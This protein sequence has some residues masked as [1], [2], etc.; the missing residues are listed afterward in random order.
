[1]GGKYGTFAIE[2]DV[3]LQ[4]MPAGQGG[5]YHG[6]AVH[7]HHWVARLDLVLHHLCVQQ[8]Q[9]RVSVRVR[10][11]RKLRRR[12]FAP[13]MHPAHASR[14]VPQRR[15]QVAQRTGHGPSRSG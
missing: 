14:C 8:R 1:M 12:L 4:D 11:L 2:H 13:G 10:V 6:L 9:P 15:R 5:A 7:G 3:V